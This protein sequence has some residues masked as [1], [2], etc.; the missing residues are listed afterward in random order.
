MMSMTLPD[1]DTM[2]SA[3]LSRDSTYEGVFFTGVR[4]TGIFCRPT[5]GARKPKPENVTFFARTQDALAA[6][7]RP[8]KLCRPMDE[9]GEPAWVKNLIRE[10]ENAEGHVLR[11]QQLRER[12]YDPAR[13]RR[14]FKQHHGITFQ[15]FARQLRIAAAYGAIRHETPVTEAAFSE[16]YESLSGFGDSFTSATGFRPSES[17]G[18]ALIVLTR[19]TTPLGP[20]VA[21]VSDGRVCLLE[22]ADRPMLETQIARIRRAFRAP[23]V[24]GS[25]PVF[26]QL[27]SEMSEY[28][29]GKRSEFEVPLATAGTPFQE[30][31]WRALREIPYGATK[32][33]SDQA[34]AIGR[35]EAVRAVAR[36]N[37]DNRIAI[38]IPCHRVIGAD[39]SLTGYGGG[40]WRKQRLL[41]IEGVSVE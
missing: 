8:C 32:S 24:A 31:V 2:V 10:L 36:A 41:E 30:S 4:T 9:P 16:G 29:T 40:L 23:V 35:P 17:S 37:G 28:F 27:H 7:F 34:R 3:F 39:G 19:I 18:R 14:W 33:Y 5:C 6:G 11:D 21:A 1:R 20:M 22:F 12:G 15:A 26:D 38:I 25:D 13:A